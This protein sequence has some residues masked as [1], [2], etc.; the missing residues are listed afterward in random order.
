MSQLLD[1]VF[2]PDD[3]IL[4][5]GDEPPAFNASDEEMLGETLPPRSYQRNLEELD[6]LLGSVGSMGFGLLGEDGKMTDAEGNVI[7]DDSDDDADE[8]SDDE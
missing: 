6:A 5:G 3:T 4:I 2:S 1:M 7:E 8:E